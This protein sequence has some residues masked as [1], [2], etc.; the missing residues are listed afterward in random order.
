V[1]PAIPEKL[2]PQPDE[3][4]FQKKLK[5]IDDKVKEIQK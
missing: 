2:L 5:E 4:T 1:I 3:A